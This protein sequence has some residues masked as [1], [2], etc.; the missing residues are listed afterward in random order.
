[1]PNQSLPW[2]DIETY[3]SKLLVSLNYIYIFIYYIVCK[4]VS[5][6]VGLTLMR[7]Q[8]GSYNVTPEASIKDL[9]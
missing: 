5:C 1:M 6:D 4:N 7:L 3:V 2:L 8:N 9:N